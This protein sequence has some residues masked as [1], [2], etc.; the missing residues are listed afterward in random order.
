MPDRARAWPL[1]LDRE[2]PLPSPEALE[3][4]CLILVDKPS[5]P[6]SFAMVT[7]L[8]RLTGIKR[9]GHAGTLD[10]FASGLMVL[11]VGQACRWQDTVMGSDKRYVAR[12]RLGAQSDSHDRTGKTAPPSEGALPGLEA[13]RAALPAY[14]GHIDQVPPM[15][16][17]VQINGKRLYLLARKGIEIERPARHVHVH[18]LEL[19]DWSP[20]FLDLDIH[21]GKGF[22]VR[23]LARDLGEALGCGALVEEL[24]RT[25]IGGYSVE[26]ALDPGALELALA[27][28]RRPVAGEAS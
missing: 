15:H 16:S 6:G 4:G 24:R 27:G 20:P 11:L 18:E 3:Q 5:G 23:S 17:A 13:I 8:R 28:L 7:L 14:R 12:L 21:C 26:R 1:L 22:Y 19:L 10:P 9:I 2:S 25:R